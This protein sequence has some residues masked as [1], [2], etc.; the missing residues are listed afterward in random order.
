[1]PTYL[2][3]KEL[4]EVRAGKGKRL[5]ITDGYKHAYSAIID[6]NLTTL[7]T[8][9]V[10]AYFGSG[11]IQGF[12]ITLIIGIFTSLFS[13]IFIT[14]LVFTYMLERKKEISFSTRLT[15][16]VFANA[17]YQFIKKRKIFYLVSAH[18]YCGRSFIVGD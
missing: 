8:A 6:A 17:N 5:A 16:K 15:E 3:T 12:A 7:F 14:R 4:E 11:P 2:S 9:I 18:Y 1:M 10:L 13:A